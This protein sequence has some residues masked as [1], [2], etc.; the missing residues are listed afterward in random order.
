MRNVSGSADFV[1]V[2][3]PL[4]AMASPSDRDVACRPRG[5]KRP[6]VT[7]DAVLRRLSRPALEAAYK[8]A[9]VDLLRATSQLADVQAQVRALQ[10]EKM[11]VFEEAERELYVE[12]LEADATA[13]AMAKGAACPICIE[14]LSDTD[15]WRLPCGHGMHGTCMLKMV[16][17][18]EN[19]GCPLCRRSLNIDVDAVIEVLDTSNIS[20]SSDSD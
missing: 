6:R 15:T 4:F 16:V 9:E 8:D 5:A 3:Q 7:A 19:V 17:V 1:L 12:Q 14:L 10:A 13:A 11:S 2:S 18:P 20:S